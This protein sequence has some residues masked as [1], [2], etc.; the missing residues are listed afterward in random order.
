MQAFHCLEYTPYD[1]E[2]IYVP[3]VSIIVPVYNSETWIDSCLLSLFNQSYLDYEVIIVNDGSTDE[4]ESKVL[5]LIEERSDF[6]Y[7][8][9]SN[10]GLSSARNKGLENAQ[11]QYVSFV[12]SDD[13]VEEGFIEKLVYGLEKYEADISI[14]GYTRIQG[15]K[16]LT[17]IS[18]QD[19][20]T[21]IIKDEDK[22]DFYFRTFIEEK[23]GVICCNKLYRRDLI[24]KSGIKF[25]E[26]KEIYAEDLLFNTQLI[27]HASKI[28]QVSAPLYNYRIRVGSITHSFKPNLEER[29]SE[30]IRRIEVKSPN[31]LPNNYAE[32]IALIQYE[33]LNVLTIN[34]F[35]EVGTLKS[36]IDC[37]KKYNEVGGKIFE[38]LIQI[39]VINSRLV[40]SRRK[41]KFFFAILSILTRIRSHNFIGL[42]FW[43]KIIVSYKKLY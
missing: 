1:T 23:H 6:R 36:I 25:E 11:G 5:N 20:F 34:A 21:N 3:K 4:S 27:M 2:W 41:F 39:R 38:R 30:L 31:L 13:W 7:I 12:D 29:Y 14:C 22:I 19:S 40:N 8:Y 9:Q 42:L 17:K 43:M 10:Q 33:A 26:N 37:V 15:D 28:V 18:I 24:Q 32:L 16:V 35:N